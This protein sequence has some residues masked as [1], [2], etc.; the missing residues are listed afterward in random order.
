[1]SSWHIILSQT[2][3]QHNLFMTFALL[4]ILG[5]A[6]IEKKGKGFLFYALALAAACHTYYWGILVVLPGH[7]FAT[8]MTRKRLTYWRQLFAYQLL[9]GLT[10]V[11]YLMPIIMGFNNVG[12]SPQTSIYAILYFW[13]ILV[14]FSSTA[15]GWID[16]VELPWVAILSFL[17]FTVILRGIWCWLRRDDTFS[18]WLGLCLLAWSLVLFGAYYVGSAELASGPLIRKF[19]LLQVPLMVGFL[20]GVANLRRPLVGRLIFSVWLISTG[21]FS[22]KFMASDYY[23]GSQLIAQKLSEIPPPLSIYSNYD[24]S[25]VFLLSS[26]GSNQEIRVH[27]FAKRTLSAESVFQVPLPTQENGTLCF[28]FMREGGH[29][30][31]QFAEFT[32]RNSSAANPDRGLNEAMAVLDRRLQERGWRKHIS[33]LYPGRIS[34]QLA[35]FNNES[36]NPQLF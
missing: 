11:V 2:A 1:L 16:L 15:W 8:L 35:C 18:Q 20:F 9:A 25:L 17:V 23:H 4:S 21:F 30:A 34:Y 10:T 26:L 7:M 36:E 13:T 28:S 19:A 6:Y 33:M 27:N 14:E 12:G 29:L 3:R 31:A 32:G 22:Y 24:Y 5:F